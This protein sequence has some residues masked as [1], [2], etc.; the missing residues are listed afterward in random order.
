MPDR[1]ELVDLYLA[2]MLE[3][4]STRDLETFFLETVAERLENLSLAELTREVRDL[5][6][7]LLPES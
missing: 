5:C 3:A 6:P 2:Q 1:S 7:E 4:M